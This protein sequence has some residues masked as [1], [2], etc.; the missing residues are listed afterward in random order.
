M[1]S[2]TVKT[3][4]N[5]F[6]KDRFQWYFDEY[7]A[8]RGPEITIGKITASKNTY[9]EDRKKRLASISK[10]DPASKTIKGRTL[11]GVWR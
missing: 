3:I 9:F 11:S 5:I 2:D 6:P 7:A 1:S 4:R 10:I 8:Y